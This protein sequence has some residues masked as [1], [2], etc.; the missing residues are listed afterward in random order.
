MKSA[1]E[2]DINEWDRDF[3]EFLNSLAQLKELGS[4]VIVFMSDH[5]EA[6]Y[7]HGYLQHVTSPDHNIMNYCMSRFTFIFLG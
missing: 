5:G 7:E 4:S 2:A 3:M 1:Y 6:F